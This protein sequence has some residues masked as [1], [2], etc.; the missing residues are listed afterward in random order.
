M[1]YQIFPHE[2]LATIG[3]M[4]GNP[5]AIALAM[6]WGPIMK[7]EMSTTEGMTTACTTKM[8]WMPG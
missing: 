1:V 7:M 2:S 6:K 3:T 4:W 5:S 8:L